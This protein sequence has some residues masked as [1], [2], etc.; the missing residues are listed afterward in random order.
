MKEAKFAYPCKLDQQGCIYKELYGEFGMLY[1]VGIAMP[2][3]ESRMSSTRAF[4]H[5]KTDDL[6]WLIFLMKFSHEGG[7]FACL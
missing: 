1:E 6:A 7:K 4:L 3:I 5:R 2:N